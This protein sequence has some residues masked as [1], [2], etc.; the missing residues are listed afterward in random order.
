MITAGKSQDGNGQSIPFL[1]RAK[2]TDSSGRAA[3]TMPTPLGCAWMAAAIPLI[4]STI[5]LSESSFRFLQSL[6]I[7]LPSLAVEVIR[8]DRVNSATLQAIRCSREHAPENHRCI[9]SV[10]DS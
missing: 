5:R 6:P 7:A 8:Q 9:L 2:K 3:V 4:C 10:S 1:H